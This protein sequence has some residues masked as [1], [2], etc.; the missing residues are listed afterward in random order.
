MLSDQDASLLHPG[1]CLAIDSGIAQLEC[2][3]YL[4]MPDHCP[5]LHSYLQAFTAV[6]SLQEQRRKPSQY[7]YGCLGRTCLGNQWRLVFHAR[8]IYSSPAHLG[9]RKAALVRNMALGRDEYHL[10]F[11]F[12]NYVVLDMLI[13]QI[14]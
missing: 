10:E 5:L 4:R 9:K 7:I 11:H 1:Y 14:T 6:K 13:F 2:Q 3:K 12:R 8:P